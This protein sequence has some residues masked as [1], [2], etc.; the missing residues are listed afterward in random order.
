[1]INP[2]TF[3]AG[4]YRRSQQVAV[5]S[6]ADRAAAAAAAAVVVESWRRPSVLG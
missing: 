6:V 4:E 3:D 1:M 5:A 2:L